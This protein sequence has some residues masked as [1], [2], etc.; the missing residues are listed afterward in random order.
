MGIVKACSSVDQLAALMVGT[1][2]VSKG[3]ARAVLSA[4]LRAFLKAV[5]RVV[6]RAVRSESRQAGCHQMITHSVWSTAIA[7]TVKNQSANY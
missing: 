6:L 4:A 2:V 5:Q 1:L 3:V 7:E